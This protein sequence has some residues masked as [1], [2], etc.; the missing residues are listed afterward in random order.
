LSCSG[1][2]RQVE[3]FER[4]ARLSF[5]QAIDATRWRVEAFAFLGP[6]W[7]TFKIQEREALSALLR[8]SE[9]R[10]RR[11]PVSITAALRCG[12]PPC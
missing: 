2:D 11:I 10:F 8:S 12:E 6:A 4:T 9:R 5:V 3:F 7:Y 1:T